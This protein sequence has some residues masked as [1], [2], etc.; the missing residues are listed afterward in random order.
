M[1]A[2]GPYG[3]VPVLAV[4]PKG[5]LRCAESLALLA[6]VGVELGGDVGNGL[7]GLVI[8]GVDAWAGRDDGLLLGLDGVEGVGEELQL[9]AHVREG[10]RDLAEE[11]RG[12][13]RPVEHLLDAH[14]QLEALEAR[15]EVGDLACVVLL[16]LV[17]DGAAVRMLRAETQMY[18]NGF[19][20]S[21]VGRER[22]LL[23]EE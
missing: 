2:K 23:R 17:H 16:H 5:D 1:K 20:G 3:V 7:L 18:R 19:R 10:P 12:G 15:Q 21:V 14:S 8:L 6:E 4:A 22:L 13:R 11:R 9:L